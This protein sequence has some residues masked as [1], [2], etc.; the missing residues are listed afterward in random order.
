MTS[1]LRSGSEIAADNDKEFVRAVTLTVDRVFDL[2]RSRTS[3]QP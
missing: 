1:S 3:S 2:R